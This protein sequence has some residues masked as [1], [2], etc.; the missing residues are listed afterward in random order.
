MREPITIADHQSSRLIVDPLHLLDCCLIS[1][2][3]VAIS[4]PP[5]SGRGTAGTA[6][7]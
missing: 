4:S 2:G 6:A 7:V 5:A 3:G 1:D